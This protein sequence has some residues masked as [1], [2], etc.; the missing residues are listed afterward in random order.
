[1]LFEGINDKTPCLEPQKNEVASSAG[2]ELETV[3]FLKTLSKGE[4]ETL[5]FSSK[6][7]KN[8]NLVRC[9]ITHEYNMINPTMKRNSD[10]NVPLKQEPILERDR[11]THEVSTEP[12]MERSSSNKV[13]PRQESNREVCRIT[14]KN[15]F[16]NKPPLSTILETDVAD[17]KKGSEKGI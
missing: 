15:A 12:E 13:L 5:G 14:R 1:M 11:I 17:S 7:P 10:N 4:R 6:K 8:R 3:K 2:D 9:S 16:N